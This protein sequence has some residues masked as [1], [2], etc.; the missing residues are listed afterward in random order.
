MS[1]SADYDSKKRKIL[2]A[3]DS[4]DQ[5]VSDENDRL[6][7]QVSDALHRLTPQKRADSMVMALVDDERQVSSSRDERLDSL[8]QMQQ[9]KV[10]VLKVGGK[11][12]QLQ[13]FSHL[14]SNLI[15]FDHP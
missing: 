2:E 14:Y 12:Y 8:Q 4:V 9:E 6:I 1:A 15:Y 11:F 5:I 3:S 7:D 13:M 10:V